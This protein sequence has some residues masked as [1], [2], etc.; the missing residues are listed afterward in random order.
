MGGFIINSLTL[1]YNNGVPITALDLTSGVP[2]QTDRIDVSRNVGFGGL[3]L[4]VDASGDVD[5]YAEYSDDGSVWARPLISDMAG[6]AT[7]EGNI[8][9]GAQNYT[10]VPIVFTARPFKFMRLV[11]DPDADSTITAKHMQQEQL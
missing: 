1:T 2:I 10:S 8:V 11:F 4:S 7:Q 6:V 5:V 3:I 9:T